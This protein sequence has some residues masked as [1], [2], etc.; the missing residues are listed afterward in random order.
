[1]EFSGKGVLITGGGS[2]VGKATALK[3]AEA[4][5][6]VAIAGRRLDRLNEV[7]NKINELGGLGLAVQC[8]VSV[9]E[10]VSEMVDRVLRS[11]G[12]VDILVNN[13]GV[14]LG[15]SVLDTELDE[16]DTVMRV[17]LT[18]AFLCTR[19]VLAHM[20]ERGEGKIIN[21]ASGG[22]LRG[23][24]MG[25][26]YC[27]SKAGMIALTESLAEE[28]RHLRINVNVVCPGPVRT[29]LFDG[30]ASSIREKIA[31][32]AMEPED[33]ANVVVFLASDA[34]KAINGQIIQV[35]NRVRW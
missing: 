13:A 25:S 24:P 15:K 7:V 35:R 28:M 2:G 4:G 26:A 20:V 33:V 5:A 12:G 30:I 10:S 22:G 34:S 18:S 6:K 19:S 16:W 9:K 21:V 17:N 31:G 11:F 29:E 23:G 32:E 1:M 14:F 8:D 27:A 3:F